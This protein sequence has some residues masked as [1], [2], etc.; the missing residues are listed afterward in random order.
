[1]LEGRESVQRGARRQVPSSGKARPDSGRIQIGIG[2]KKKAA[3][4]ER[5]IKSMQGSDTAAMT[6]EAQQKRRCFS[7]SGVLCLKSCPE[8]L[9]EGRRHQIGVELGRLSESRQER[10]DVRHSKLA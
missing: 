4:L 3:K 9:K 6:L 5:G 7:S 10:G 8:D 1:M 2:C